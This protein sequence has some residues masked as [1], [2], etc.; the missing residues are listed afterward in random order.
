M[1]ATKRGIVWGVLSVIVSVGSFVLPI[2]ALII[3]TVAGKAVYDVLWPI[4]LALFLCFPPI[5]FVLAFIGKVRSASETKARTLC[6]VGAGVG[7]VLSAVFLWMMTGAAFQD[8]LLLK[9]DAAV[10]TALIDTCLL[11]GY[12]LAAYIRG[13]ILWFI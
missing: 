8:F 13:K 7:I 10:I 5:G 3:G 9:E 12:F 11:T 6:N 4:A 2:M 1:L